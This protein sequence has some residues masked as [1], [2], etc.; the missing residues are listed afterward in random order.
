[1]AYGL[2]NAW[3][4]AP[5]DIAS[6]GL[7]NPG[8][9]EWSKFTGIPATHALVGGP[10][11]G[12]DSSGFNLGAGGDARVVDAVGGAAMPGGA[13]PPGTPAR[14][15]W[16]DWR[17]LLDPHSPMLWLLLFAAGALSL[18]HVRVQGRVGSARAAAG[19][20]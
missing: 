18:I 2:D 9:D 11:Y 3:V 10:G 12:P 16:N 13:P 5:P 6:A 19:V 20:G 14:S 4:M 15:R 8:V 1:M 7:G 17:E